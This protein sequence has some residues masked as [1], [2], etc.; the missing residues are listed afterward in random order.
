M[1][2]SEAKETFIQR[3][4]DLGT[5]WGI[6]RTMAQ[7]HALLLVSAK[8]HCADDI[9]EL[10]HI[11]R[12][13]ACMNLKSLVEW[14][15]VYKKCREGCRK[16]YY[17]AEKD[18]YQVFRQIIIHRRKEELEPLLLMMENYSDIE[19]NCTESSEF[20]KVVRDIKYFSKKADSTLDSL[21]KTSPDW[22]VGSFLRMF[23]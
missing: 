8:P 17:V 6:N 2:F 4:G 10:L 19:E 20:C 3:W 11:S 13:N 12:G 18:M 9:I 23:R 21:L 5:K 16:E 1:K 22:F 7:I 15:L 14:G